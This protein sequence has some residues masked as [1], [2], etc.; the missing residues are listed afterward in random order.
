MIRITVNAE[1]K[2]VADGIT[3]ADLLE[4]L[5]LSGKPAAVEINQALVPKGRHSE[6][7]IAEG[8]A[9]EIVTLVGGG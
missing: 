2:G 5:G 9:I 8:D 7:E 1:E 6:Q 4:E 3:V